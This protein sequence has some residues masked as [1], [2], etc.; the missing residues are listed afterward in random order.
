M[1][2]ATEDPAAADDSVA[3]AGGHVPDYSSPTYAPA[4]P[5]YAT[6]AYAAS[7][8]GDAAGETASSEP[9]AP[10]QPAPQPLAHA[11]ATP[12]Y[13]MPAGSAPHTYHLPPDAGY[14]GVALAEPPRDA[15]F[16]PA[17]M[18][19]SDLKPP[20]PRSRAL[21]VVALVLAIVG[22]LATFAGAVGFSALAL[23]TAFV[24]AIVALAGRRHGGKGIGASALILS[25]IAG[26]L[27][28]IIGAL[29]S[30]TPD[31]AYEPDEY[32]GSEQG[33]N[34]APV[35]GRLVAP[36]TDGLPDAGSVFAEPV[37]A[38][39]SATAFGPESE[40]ISWYAVVI[41]NPNADY[42]FDAPVT[43]RALGSDGAELATDARYVTLLA[44]RTVLVG[45]LAGDDI[46]SLAVELPE[47]SFATLAPALETG[48]FAATDVTAVATGSATTVNGTLTA[49]FADDQGLVEISVLVRAADGT[50]LD[51][52]SGAVGEVPGDGTPVPFTVWIPREI[53]PGAT[54]EAYPHR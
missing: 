12:A 25:T 31:T 30:A 37:P 39:V 33:E 5:E 4:A 16:A 49:H 35:P 13:A 32:Y 46:A 28:M 26:L 1:N 18:P 3:P 24:L 50:I 48:S 47:A 40:G 19:T 27:A 36:G 53:P 45:L 51:A 23:L 11:Y 17:P 6:P 52:A 41:D 14:A 10:P 22:T 8:P 7:G 34:Y 2:G 29:S 15:W 43:V 20:A 9:A 44:G 38:T 42:V 21:A 54:V